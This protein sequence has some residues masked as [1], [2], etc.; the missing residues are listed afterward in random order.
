MGTPIE[1]GEV[2]GT[3]PTG[4]SSPGLNPAWGEALSA[5]P[6]Q[7]HGYLTP[8]FEKW[9]QSAQQR[10]ESVNQQLSQFEPFKPLVENGI[11]YQDVEQ[12]LQLMYQINTNP[13]AVYNALRE[14]YGFDPVNE[15]EASEEE[16][17]ENPQTFQDP[18]V[19]QLQGYLDV[20]AQTIVQQQEREAAAKADAELEAELNALS[21]KYPNFDERY[22]LSL[23][24]N[25]ATMEEAAEAYSALVDNVLQQNPRPFAPQVMGTSGG[26]TGLPSQAIDPRQ[27]TGKDTRNL[28]VQ[29]L[30]AANRES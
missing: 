10:I 25:G 28:V 27:L 17:E 4:E 8:H 2:Q 16:E 6:E 24:A 5:I 26:G 23:V 14:A 29:M 13:Q 21:K 18:R 11:G 22:V 1:G 7:F 19:D 12:G 20:V 9:D 3:E 30:N 15:P